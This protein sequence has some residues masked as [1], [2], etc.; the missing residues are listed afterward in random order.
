MN[1]SAFYFLIGVLLSTSIFASDQ[2]KYEKQEVL[3]KRAS[4]LIIGSAARANKLKSILKKDTPTGSKQYIDPIK[5]VK[6]NAEVK[7]C[8]FH[9]P[10]SITDYKLADGINNQ[11]S[12]E[13]KSREFI[14]IMTEKYSNKKKKI[15]YKDM[16]LGQYPQKS[17][18]IHKSNDVAMLYAYAETEIA[19]ADKVLKK[20]NTSKS[21][22]SLLKEVTHRREALRVLHLATVMATESKKENYKYQDAKDH[23]KTQLHLNLK[24]LFE[25]IQLTENGEYLGNYFYLLYANLKMAQQYEAYSQL[26]SSIYHIDADEIY[27]SKSEETR[28]NIVWQL[29]S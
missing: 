12:I 13:E 15:I 4:T 7:A 21:T 14:L 25:L 11:F 22:E 8:F 28:E 24:N 6:F 5:Q 26:L 1:Y 23:I 18:N 10:P 2:F 29:F 20:R 3:K 19:L 17:K 9:K 16:E 27:E